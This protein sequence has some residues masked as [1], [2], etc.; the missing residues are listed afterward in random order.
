[1]Y[2]IPLLLLRPC[3]SVILAT[4]CSMNHQVSDILGGFAICLYRPFDPRT[5]IREML[6]IHGVAF[7]QRERSVLVSNAAATMGDST[8]VNTYLATIQ[9]KYV[10]HGYPWPWYSMEG[11]WFMRVN[12]FMAGNGF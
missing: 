2:A 4:P 10:S 7:L 11:G 8:R 12:A 6:R 9:N 5:S 1:M 3:A